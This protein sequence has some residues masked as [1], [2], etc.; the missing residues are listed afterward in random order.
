MFIIWKCNIHSFFIV[1]CFAQSGITPTKF[2]VFT[3]HLA[4]KA[5]DREQLF[6]F[7]M[8]KSPK[9]NL[10]SANMITIMLIGICDDIFFT[11]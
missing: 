4:Y 10:S 2:R 1:F 5:E 8:S 6:S 3:L 9:I 11:N 7:F